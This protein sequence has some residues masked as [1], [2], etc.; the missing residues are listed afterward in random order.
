MEKQLQNYKG[1]VAYALNKHKEVL[2]KVM[3]K[4]FLSG[5]D[6]SKLKNIV[7]EI[8]TADAEV[9]Q[10]EAKKALAMLDNSKNYSRHY[11]ST[12]AAYMTGIAVG[13]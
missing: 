11:L 8:L 6:F 9:S 4:P 2:Y 1:T 3:N 12:L 5:E 7:N 13:K 10:T